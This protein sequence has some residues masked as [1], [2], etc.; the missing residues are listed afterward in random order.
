MSFTKT[1]VLSLGAGVQ[2][3]TL[4]ILCEKGIIEKPDFA[5]FADTQAE[6]KAVYDYLEYLKSILSFPVYVI[7][8]GNIIKDTIKNEYCSIPLHIL[9]SDG[10]KGLGK[11]TCTADYKI[12]PINQAVRRILG[13][14]PNEKTKHEVEM[15]LGIS[16][17]EI[18]RMKASPKKWIT[19]R[20]PLIEQM[21]F[22]RQD[23]IEFMGKNNIK[24]PPRSACYMCPYRN[25][26]EWHILKTDYPDEWQKAVEFDDKIRSINIGLKGK[27][28]LHKSC[29]PL[30]DVQLKPQ[31]EN[32]QLGIFS[33][34]QNECEGMCGI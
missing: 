16:V 7:S 11:R 24:K 21:N 29:K 30:K 34:M 20:Y 13:Y 33:E 32:T 5:I 4:A 1:R 23:C 3:S 18:Q 28:Y 17:D 2:S 15:L 27:P 31:F 22:T 26:L 9:H 10:T 25:D 12:Y 6:P 19:N 8:H 14:K